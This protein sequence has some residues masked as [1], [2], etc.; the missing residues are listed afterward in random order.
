MYV[1][2]GLQIGPAGYYQGK[3]WGSLQLYVGSQLWGWSIV[4]AQQFLIQG[5]EQL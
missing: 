2:I 4:L 1:D 5:Y 3:Q